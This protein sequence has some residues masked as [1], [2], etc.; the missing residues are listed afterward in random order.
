MLF[1]GLGLRHEHAATRFRFAPNRFNDPG[2]EEGNT[3]VHSTS[4][5]P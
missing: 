5:A 2:P 4:L 3:G 1:L